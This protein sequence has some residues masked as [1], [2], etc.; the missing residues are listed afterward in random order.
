[1]PRSRAIDSR[2]RRFEGFCLEPHFAVGVKPAFRLQRERLHA[3]GDGAADVYRD[4]LR[5][6]ERLERRLVQLDGKRLDRRARYEFFAIRQMREQRTLRSMRVSFETCPGADQLP[7]AG[8]PRGERPARAASLRSRARPRHAGGNLQ[9]QR[10]ED[11]GSRRWRPL[12]GIE[13][14]NPDAVVVHAG[15]IMRIGQRHR[16]LDAGGVE[17]AFAGE[18][19]KRGHGIAQRCLREPGPERRVLIQQAMPAI[20]RLLFVAAQWTG[21]V[22]SELAQC[23]EQTGRPFGRRAARPRQCRERLAQA[24]HERGRSGVAGGALEKRSQLLGAELE[25]P[26][27]AKHSFDG[28][29]GHHVIAIEKWQTQPPHH[30]IESQATGEQPQTEQ[31]VRNDREFGQ[32]ASA[33]DCEHRGGGPRLGAYPFGRRESLRQ[34][35]VIQIATLTQFRVDDEQPAVRIAFQCRAAPCGDQFEL[36]LIILRGGDCD[37]RL[38]W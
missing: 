33:F 16:R 34:Q 37:W 3:A 10:N 9:G 28:G 22:P 15:I 21:A 35:A 7:G 29:P 17:V 6:V 36:M 23:R 31:R 12:R 24:Q 25:L 20:H 13:A 26:S 11:V 19:R 5:I 18:I 14:G 8:T 27:V 4:A 32:R 1:M 2:R 38:P 30:F